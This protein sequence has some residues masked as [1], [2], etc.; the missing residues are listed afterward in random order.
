MKSVL[1]F[2][3]MILLCSASLHAQQGFLERK[4]SLSATGKISA[5]L[6]Q[7]A[8]AGGFSFSYSTS[9]VKSEEVFTINANQQPVREVLDGMFH[10]TLL[11]REK[12]NHIILSKAPAQR[13]AVQFIVLS[14]HIKDAANAKPMK[15]VSVYDRNSIS[16]VITDEDGYFQMRVDRKGQEAHVSV[17]KE[18]Y[19]DTTLTITGTGNQY[20][21]INLR[22]FMSDTFRLASSAP[23]VADTTHHETL[24]LPYE[25]EPNVRNISDTLY[26][27]IQI[28]FLPFLGSNGSLSGN[29]INNYSIN[30]LGGYALG[31]RQIEL[32]FFLN[33]D[34]GDVSWLQ[35]AGLANLVGR[36]V[37]GVQASGFANLNGGEVKAAQLTGIS[38]VNFGDF[39]GVQVGGL[40]NVNLEG[41]D[42]V[43]VAGL[44]NI[45]QAPSHGVQVAGVTNI[46]RGNYKGS[47]FAGVS[48]FASQHITGSQIS[49]IFN[50]GNNVHGT[51]IGLFNFADSL[52]GVPVGLVS[53]VSSGYH[54]LEV[55]ADEVFFANLAFRTGARQFYNILMAGIKPEQS[56]NPS[57]VW[58]FGYGVGTAPRIFRWMH[59]NLDLTAQHVTRGEF[60]DHLSLLTKFHTGFDFRLSRKLS[61]YTGVTLNAYFTDP[62]YTDY[63]VLF[64]NYSPNIIHDS[65]IDST[66]RMQM[67]WGF[68][69]GVRIL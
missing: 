47:Q 28:S 5:L 58:T 1:L 66:T 62:T 15:D 17:S 27:D 42:G 63:P 14:G 68:K 44:A 23:V 64:T 41:G 59:L 16:S 11:Y 43:S 9:A 8:K 45:T 36:N 32:G 29:V 18:G 55:S 51:Q 69:V 26:R 48:N 30:I 7:I 10:G 22:A 25:D 40:A 50:Y 31:T 13:A 46:Q 56:V 52:G 34:R 4:I 54:K 49:A 53:F 20:L 6:D 67:W 60:T 33:M 35:V 57:G 61:V 65:N 24:T 38:N 19:R 12:G 2:V 3:G 37:Y 39:Q 21:G